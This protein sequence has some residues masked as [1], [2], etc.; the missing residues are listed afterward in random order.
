MQA[1]IMQ[2]CGL[3]HIVPMRMIDI[4]LAQFDTMFARIADDLC[5]CIKAHG[6]RIEQGA[7]KDIGIATF[8]PSRGIDKQCEG[9][10]MAFR[11]AISAKAFNLAKASFCKSAVI[12][13]LR[14]AP[15]G[16]DDTAV[17]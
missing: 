17:E 10:G 4:D 11:K 16:G 5:G 8:H 7:G 9:G 13:T 15:P 3:E 1:Q 2:R 12:A 6:L 14:H